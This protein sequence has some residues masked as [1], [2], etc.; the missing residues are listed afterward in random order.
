MLWTN[1]NKLLGNG[2]VGLKTGI[3]KTAGSCLSAIY[4]PDDEYTYDNTLVII[5]LNCK[6]IDDRFTDT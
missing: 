5:V 1:T 2:F 6:I 3:T 4:Q